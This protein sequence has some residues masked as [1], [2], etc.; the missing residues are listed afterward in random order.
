MR[1]LFQ[2]QGYLPMSAVYVDKVRGHCRAALWQTFIRD[3]AAVIALACAAFLAP[4][5]T[6][7]TLGVILL[8][9]M[10]VGRV[11]LSSPMVLAVVLGVTLA[12]VSDGIR[13]RASFVAP[14]IGLGACFLIYMADICG[15]SGRC[16]NCGRPHRSAAEPPATATPRPVELGGPLHA[17]PSGQGGRPRRSCRRV[18]PVRSTTTRTG[19]SGR[20]HLSRPCRSPSRSTSRGTPQGH[21]RSSRPGVARRTSAITSSP[22]EPEDGQLHGRARA[23]SGRRWRKTG[24]GRGRAFHL[25]S[26]VPGCGGSAWPAPFPEPRKI[27][28][29]P[30]KIM[31]LGHPDLPATL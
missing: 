24:P 4:W 5:G 12:L 19:S 27:P 22:R 1:V 9:I 26:A 18:A 15:R 14:L 11:R 28:L 25:R 2:A 31:R 6:A 29:L 30:V 23:P 7:I 13:E 21:Q 20:A 10:V 8:I 3:A 17:G 16:G